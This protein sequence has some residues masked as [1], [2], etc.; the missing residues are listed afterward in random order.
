MGITHFDEARTRDVGDRPPAGAGAFLGEQPGPSAAG[1][2]GSNRR[3]G[4][5]R[6][7]R[8]S[9]APRRRSS[10]SSPAG[11]SWQAREDRRGRRRRLHRVPRG[12]APTPC[13]RSSGIDC[14]H[15]VP[16]PRRERGFPRLWMSL[17]GGRSSRARR[18]RTARRSNSC[19]RRRSGPPSSRRSLD[20]ARTIVNLEE[21]EAEVWSAR[22]RARPAQSRSRHGSV[23]RPPARRC[24]P[25]MQSAP[26]TAIR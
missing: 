6:R 24:R 19:A 21:V 9:T 4:R 17:N 14:S 23:S 12:R 18:A 7:R 20:H 3:P 11:G 25:G 8:T 16:R 10:I 2:G 26:R 13:T 22:A 5:G 1:Y 15:S